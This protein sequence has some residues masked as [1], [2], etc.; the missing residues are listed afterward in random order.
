MWWNVTLNCVMQDQHMHSKHKLL[1]LI[2]LNRALRSSPSLSVIWL[3]A[4]RVASSFESD[5]LVW[6]VWMCLIS[7]RMMKMSGLR[8][9]DSGSK[10]NAQAFKQLAE[11]SKLA[12]FLI[13]P[14]IYRPCQV[15]RLMGTGCGLLSPSN[16][17][18]N[19]VPLFS[20]APYLDGSAG[21]CLCRQ[22]MLAGVGHHMLLESDTVSWKPDE[23]YSPI[24]FD[25]DYDACI[26]YLN[27]RYCY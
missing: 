7:V 4:K 16:R 8:V 20:W 22:Q 15:Q 14:L 27:H 23:L 1:K 26:H 24:E 2:K 17:P 3:K 12:G 6:C 9:H 18:S 25:V 19:H 13:P 21:S 10:I 5:W 11:A